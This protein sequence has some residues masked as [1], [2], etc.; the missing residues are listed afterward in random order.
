MRFFTVVTALTW[1]TLM[2][3]TITSA[4]GQDAL[5]TTYVVLTARR[6]PLPQAF[7][8]IQQKTGLLFV[9][10]PGL[11]DVYKD[12]RMPEG[13]FTVAQAL[14][15]V[16][17]GTYLDYTE[18]NRNIIVFK[19]PTL[20]T[21]RGRVTERDTGEPL[22]MVNVTVKDTERGTRTDI[23]GNFEIAALSD[24]IL[25]FSFTSL[26]T[27]EVK[28]NNT[29]QFDVELEPTQLET[30]PINAGY[31]V[32][33][34]EQ[35][36]GNI[37]TISE[38]D[39]QSQITY[40]PLQ[41]MQGQMT[42]VYIQQSSGIPGAGFKVS[43]RG[44]NTLREDDA[45]NAPLY[46][47]DGVPFPSASFASP[48]V[49]YVL[50]NNP[51]PL[52]TINPNAIE[53][54][55]VL[56]DADATAIYGSRGANGVV[57]IRTRRRVTG[58]TRVDLNV[59]TGFNEVPHM[60][61]LLDTK[62][63]LTMRRE[64]FKND[65]VAMT[66][67]N[68]RDLLRW[69]TTRYTDWQKV[70]IGGRARITNANFSISGGAQ[71][72][73][74][75]FGGTYYREGT[76]FP[77][78]FDLGYTRAAAL[79][80]L[81]H[82]SNDDKLRLELSANYSRDIN[83]LPGADLTRSAVGLVPIAPAIYTPEGDLNWETGATWTN[84]YSNLI[85]SFE[86]NANTLVTQAGLSYKVL[87]GFSVKADIGYTYI[88]KRD[89]YLTPIASLNPILADR[90][91]VN[92][93]ASPQI[94]TWIGEPR[95]EYSTTI[96]EGKLEALVGTTFQRSLL[97]SNT[98]VADG[99]KSDALLDN[100]NMA[101]VIT[102]QEPMYELYKY[103]AVFSRINY[104][105]K[106]RYMLNLTARRDGSSRF[107][108]DH[109]FANFGAI[110]AGWI[111]TKEPIMG[112]NAPW[113]SFGK[114]RA[115]AGVTGSDQIGEYMFMDTYQPTML[116][117]PGQSSIVPVRLVN[118][119]YS[120]EQTSKLEVGL[121]VGVWNNRVL[122]DVALYRNRTS[123][124]LVGRPLPD[125]TGFTSVQ[126]NQ[127]AIV[128]N[129]G[130]EARL[131]ATL[132]RR[133]RFEW[134]TAVNITFPRTKLERYDGI[135]KS[136]YARQYVVGKSI[137]RNPRFHYTGVDPA[138]GLYTFQDVDDNGNYDAKDYLAL[139][140]WGIRCFGG[141]QN[142][143]RY[144]AF[145]LDFL[146]QFVK[147]N[148]FSYHHVWTSA[149]GTR[150]TNWPVDVMQRWQKDG[151]ITDVQ[152]FSQATVAGNLLNTFK[153]SDGKIVDG[154]FIRLK[155]AALSYNVSKPVLD[156]LHLQRLRIYVQG[157]NLL[158]FTDYVGF[159]PENPAITLPPLRSVAAGIQ[160][161]F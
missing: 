78:G 153:A 3:G 73:R 57:L 26:K 19:R 158:T 56:K 50:G 105:L 150:L 16:L 15:S 67:A 24:D 98:L 10:Q 157:Q 113:L 83:K 39:I 111:F 51:S 66:P 143:I 107:G 112:N 123:R 12:V 89:T 148:V 64:A 126:S 152:R 62:Q 120:W 42:G 103:S 114:I 132:V 52:A 32:V 125:I 139:K 45:S 159:D 101:G 37:A 4:Q 94:T 44:Q 71:R 141:V 92:A 38:E 40:N 80:T 22:E 135:E 144:G 70:L 156:R 41:A 90:S 33:P 63:Y 122:V 2:I 60:V 116:Q 5:E 119:E 87:K 65:G 14:D 76:V 95:L 147:Q 155:T 61:D 47:I 136:E 18:S 138:T 140:E 27:R 96:G 97:E 23:N 77:K 117:Y 35:A 108:P 13:R 130:V 102:V 6:M 137:Y 55:S 91:G 81:V 110:G 30:V 106:N 99:Y 36:V 34:A 21:V 59:Y 124:Q 74:F 29:T 121:N 161:T 93:T 133:E 48:W 146:F 160:V 1:C 25:L 54:I 129:S 128:Q 104:T 151:D 85:Q 145:Q 118:T 115:S 69:D 8:Q 17:V 131:N 68:A 9:Y 142:S 53:S 11:V 72:T 84:P 46:I 28:V 88:D 20:L 154:S 75:L 43:V 7:R 86:S 58:E 49:S 134:S 79:F 31:Y 100:L 149:P 127:P 82:T 109:R